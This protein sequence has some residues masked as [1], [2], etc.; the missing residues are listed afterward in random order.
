MLP[1]PVVWIGLDISPRRLREFVRVQ[2]NLKHDRTENTRA[3]EI[4]GFRDVHR[5]RASPFLYVFLSPQRHDF[6]LP[7][8]R[9]EISSFERTPHRPLNLDQSELN[10]T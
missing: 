9:R 1:D 7:E 10:R 8:S 3:L 5:L 4:L 2:R 6:K